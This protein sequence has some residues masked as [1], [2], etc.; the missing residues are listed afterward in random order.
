MRRFIE[1]NIPVHFQ[2]DWEVSASIGSLCFVQ[3]FIEKKIPVHFQV[4]WKVSGSIGK[5]VFRT[6]LPLKKI[7]VQ[8]QVDRNVGFGMGLPSRRHPSP[9]PRSLERWVSYGASAGRG[10]HIYLADELSSSCRGVFQVACPGT[11]TLDSTAQLTPRSPC[12]P[13]A[14]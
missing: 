4:D 14:C 10:E 5:L 2:V 7:P 1:K 9:L 13:W 6:T 3:R 8:L 11:A 12:A